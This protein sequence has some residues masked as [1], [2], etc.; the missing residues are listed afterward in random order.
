MS[1]GYTPLLMMEKKMKKIQGFILYRIY[2]KER[3]VYLGRTKQPLQDRIRGH[4]F[5]KPMHRSIYIDQVSKIEYA[6][7]QTEA[8]MNLYEIYFINLWKPTLNID[9]RAND[10][11]T[12]TLPPVE[13]K[14][15]ETPLWEKWK[16]ELEKTDNQYKMRQEEKKALQE[17]QREMRRRWH[18]EEISEEEYYKFKEVSEKGQVIHDPFQDLEKMM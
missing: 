11:L 7:F 3:I 8:D 17:M 4:L 1:L 10:K 9:D 16:K 13:W 2:Y 15:F 18:N 6:E 14:V 5:K 12:V